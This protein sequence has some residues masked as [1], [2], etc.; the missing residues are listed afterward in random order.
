M[1]RGARGCVKVSGG[2][3]RYMRI[4]GSLDAPVVSM[5]M[6]VVS[7]WC[8][9]GRWEWIPELSV[10]LAEVWMDES[11]ANTKLPSSVPAIAL[12]HPMDPDRLFFFLGSSILAVD[13]QLRKVVGFS[14]FEMLEPPCALRRKRSSR[15]VHAW[16]HDP[17][18]TRTESVS[19]CLRQEKAIAAMSSYPARR[20]N[21]PAYLYPMVKKVWDLLTRQEQEKEQQ[22]LQLEQ[23]WRQRA[24]CHN[25]GRRCGI[26][27]ESRI[28]LPRLSMNERV[29]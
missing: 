29:E 20:R 15:F 22:W 16:Q 2:R 28:S 11:Y 10:P 13:L 3:L 5:W 4:H 18:S 9:A 21:V 23:Q 7:T 19:A 24:M 1:D 17:S 14:E 25:F 27:E 26:S 8:P 6:A 12:I